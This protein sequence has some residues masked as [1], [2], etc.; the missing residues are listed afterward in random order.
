MTLVVAASGPRL[1]ASPPLRPG[2]DMGGRLRGS[3]LPQRPEHMA[4][5]G[6]GQW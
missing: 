6:H 1:V 3:G 2:E 5:F 4:N